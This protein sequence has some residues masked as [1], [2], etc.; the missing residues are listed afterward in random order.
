MKKLILILLMKRTQLTNYLQD[1]WD[2]SLWLIILL[3]PN[4]RRKF[5]IAA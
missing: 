4:I 1:K 5:K 2:L 3:I